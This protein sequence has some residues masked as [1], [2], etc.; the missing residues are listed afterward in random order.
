MHSRYLYNS[1]EFMFSKVKISL[2]LTPRHLHLKYHTW[3][4]LDGWKLL[5]YFWP[6]RSKH[7]YCW[8]L[9]LL[10]IYAN[11]NLESFDMHVG[12][13]KVISGWP[14]CRHLRVEHL[15]DLL[16]WFDHC[17]HMPLHPI[18]HVCL[19]LLLHTLAFLDGVLNHKWIL[20]HNNCHDGMQ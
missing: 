1:K 19:L 15:F 7:L 8:V 16:N 14:M 20:V 6:I 13:S 2:F 3:R 4:Y 12:A 5:R 10:I 9:S 18:S 17:I 11:K